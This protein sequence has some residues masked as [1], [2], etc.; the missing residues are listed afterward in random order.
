MGEADII[1][2]VFAPLAA[3]FEGAFGLKDDAAAIRPPIGCDLV[4]TVDAVAA[5]VHFFSDDDAA[6]IGWKALAVNV[7][8]LIAKGAAPHAYVMSLAFPEMPDKAW[9]LGLATGLAEAQRAFGITLIGGDTDRRPGPVSITITA[10][11]FVPAG[12]MVKRTTAK[13]GDHVFVSG[14]LGDSA[15]GLTLRRDG[16]MSAPF[17]VSAVHRSDLIG[18]YLRPRPPLALVPALRDFASA[19]MDISD[20][21]VKDLTR[22]ADASGV[23]ALI[24]CEALPLS[25][26]ARAVVASH[27]SEM[28]SIATGGDDYQVLATVSPQHVAAFVAAACV[29]G[30]TVSEIGRIIVGHGVA[31]LGPDGNA[32][33]F[34][35]TGY[36][37]F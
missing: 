37:H 23:G 17:T 3:G 35:S 19:S 30:V 31:I 7:S 2:G 25:D 11:G 9:L 1:Q 8:D 16:A 22:M 32:I 10:I 29:A 24:D 27:P 4:V 15:L 36:D 21:L 18:R 33:S 26:A 28:A 12:Q 6:D 14:A 34:D 20:G 5:G 13:A